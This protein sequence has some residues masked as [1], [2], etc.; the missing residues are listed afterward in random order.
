[1]SAGAILSARKTPL[2]LCG[3]ERDETACKSY[4]E[5][6]EFFDEKAKKRVRKKNSLPSNISWKMK[7]IWKR[8]RNNQLKMYLKQHGLKISGSKADVTTRVLRP[9]T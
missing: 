7:Q 4:V 8:L 2:S 6:F 1:V 5:D 3:G 9:R